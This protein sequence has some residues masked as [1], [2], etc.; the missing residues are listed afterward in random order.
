MLQI[1]LSPRTAAN[2]AHQQAA[3]SVSILSQ[4]LPPSIRFYRATK[5]PTSI[6]LH[7]SVTNHDIAQAIKMI[8]GASGHPDG[9]RIVVNAE[10]IA[11]AND[12]AKLKQLGSFAIDIGFKGD[13]GW[14]KRFVSIEREAAG[15]EDIVETAAAATPEDTPPA[16]SGEGQ[17][18]GQM[19]VK[20]FSTPPSTSGSKSKAGSDQF[21]L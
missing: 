18:Q 13:Q 7:G 20:L 15:V 6:E 11:I 17:G 8:A 1:Y 4:I 19:P 16:L 2:V 5:T 10:N 3:E 21:I 9:R 12:T 14:V